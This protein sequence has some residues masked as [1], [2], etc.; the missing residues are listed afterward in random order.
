MRL[1]R[2]LGWV[3]V[4]RS[5][6]VSLIPLACPLSSLAL[7]IPLLLGMVVYGCVFTAVFSLALLMC[8]LESWK[9]WL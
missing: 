9:A 1:A 7:L 3:L 8:V 6:L 4:R 2:L 5:S